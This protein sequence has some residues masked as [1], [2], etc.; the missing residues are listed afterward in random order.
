MTIKD[1]RGALLCLMCSRP[2][3]VA[4][5]FIPDE[6]WDWVPVAAPA[7][8]RSAVAYALCDHCHDRLDLDA[9]EAQLRLRLRRSMS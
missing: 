7:G 6:P 4:A 9:I 1:R 2:A 8:K 5:L 3:E